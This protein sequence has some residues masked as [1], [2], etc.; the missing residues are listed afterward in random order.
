MVTLAI[1]A[2]VFEDL[3]QNVCQNALDRGNALS[4]LIETLVTN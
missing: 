1:V 3:G 4:N 2:P